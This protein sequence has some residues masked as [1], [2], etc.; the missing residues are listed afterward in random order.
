MNGK[1]AWGWGQSRGWDRVIA[2]A[3]GLAAAAPPPAVA[4]T[5]F[6][7]DS[8]PD[9]S[10]YTTFEECMAASMRVAA[11][12]RVRERFAVGWAD[13]ME[14]LHT[15]VDLWRRELP[16]T[17]P[18]ALEVTTTRQCLAPFSAADTILD[19][20][21]LESVMRYLLRA[22]RDAD[23][24][25][26]FAR[27]LAAVPTT[28]TA[29]IAIKE[30][31]LRAYEG[32]RPIRYAEAERLL[33]EQMERQGVDKMQ[34]LQNL[35]QLAARAGDT[36]RAKTFARQYFAGHYVDSVKAYW[37]DNLAK[38][39][40]SGGSLIRAS[41]NYAWL[42]LLMAYEDSLLDTLKLGTM[43][44][45]A[46]RRALLAKAI[47]ADM[48]ARLNPDSLTG[49][50]APT[51]SGDFWFGH[52]TLAG[53]RPTRGKVGLVF[54]VEGLGSP[55]EIN[56]AYKKAIDAVD[57]WTVSNTLSGCLTREVGD[58][59]NGN[60]YELASYLSDTPDTLVND[61]CW[62]A[63]VSVRRLMRRFPTLEVTLLSATTGR[64]LYRALPDSAAAEAEMLQRWLLQGHQLKGAALAVTRSKFFR[65]PAPDRRLMR[66]RSSDPNVVQYEQLGG[67]P[68]IGTA[69]LVD[70][71]GLLVDELQ[72]YRGGEF[73][74]E[75]GKL[76][77]MIDAI[78]QQP[79]SHP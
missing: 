12:E 43:R 54:F 13:T 68:R 20:F 55:Q 6:V 26:V 50:P 21:P 45:K 49:K 37:A 38:L 5:R 63:L 46:A 7:W 4:Q 64:T 48:V 60:P 2:L 22:G 61:R 15:L 40:T 71:D 77:K 19:V 8:I 3:V 59:G 51:L 79:V 73:G 9:V 1:T 42:K 28:D 18:S 69:Y 41:A 32:A 31:A 65:L 76:G 75:E 53:Q 33:K 58:L 62:S 44:W 10:R 66:L 39:D 27:R 35:T 57:G 25:A 17:P 14:N 34:Q 36:V 30:Q 16:K 11:A 56:M 72:F 23:A 47:G 29:A 74:F 24:A 78:L 70:R 67:H 52:D